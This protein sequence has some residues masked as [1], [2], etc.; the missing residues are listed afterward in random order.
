MLRPID[1]GGKVEK[2]PEVTAPA[3]ALAGCAK[4]FFCPTCIGLSYAM[5][6]SLMLHLQRDHAGKGAGHA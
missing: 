4:R 2:P 5:R 6:V 1:V 3:P